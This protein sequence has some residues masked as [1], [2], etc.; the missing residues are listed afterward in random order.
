MDCGQAS[1]LMYNL[2]MLESLRLVWGWM[3]T[4]LKTGYMF[5]L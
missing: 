1:A 2:T 3:V 5:Q 4:I